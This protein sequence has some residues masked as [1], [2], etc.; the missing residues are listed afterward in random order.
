MNYVKCPSC[1]SVL[2]RRNGQYGEFVGCSN[3]PR[4]NFTKNLVDFSEAELEMIG[5]PV[6]SGRKGECNRCGQIRTLNEMGLC[7]SCEEWYERQ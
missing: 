5:Y 2:V 6:Y 7:S 4:C 1:E 3:W